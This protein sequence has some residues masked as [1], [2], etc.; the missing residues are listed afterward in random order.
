M[1]FRKRQEL[2]NLREKLQ[3]T[4]INNDAAVQLKKA[5]DEVSYSITYMKEAIYMFGRSCLDL[6]FPV[7]W[8]RVIQIN[9][10]QPIEL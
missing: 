1:V 2:E 3:N 7:T 6:C 10:H 8:D 5:E 9:G 4:N